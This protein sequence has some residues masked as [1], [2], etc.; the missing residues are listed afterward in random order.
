MLAVGKRGRSGGV[1]VG[2]RRFRL[3]LLRAEGI[4]KYF[5]AGGMFFRGSKPVRAVDGVDLVLERGKTLG[6][7]GESGCGKSTL[8]R[9]LLR[10]EEPTGGNLYLDGIDF[11]ALRGRE[12]RRTRR[13]IQMVFQDPYSSLNPRMSIGGT[14][15]E[16]L[17]IHGL[18]RGRAVR[19]RVAYLLDK[20]GLP[21]SAAGRYP[22]EFSGGQRQRIGIARALAVE[23][24]II[25]ADEP[26][27][28]LDVSV[29]AQIINLL[30]DL[31]ADLNL[32]CLLIAH[33]LG[34]VEHVSERVAVMYL[35]KIVEAAPAGALFARPLHPYTQGLL[36]S[37]PKPDPSAPR[38]RAAIRGDVPSPMDVPAGCSFHTRC[39]EVM[40]R[41]RTEPPHLVEIE[42]GRRVRCWLH[43]PTPS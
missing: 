10:L 21:P 35:G 7:V 40:P 29:R 30:G 2:G 37:I 8:A 15:S 41:C 32:A 25:V 20:V 11:L 22:H 27:S 16:G 14:I 26:V 5:R 43:A 24:D 36:A 28:A 6:L 23:P 4:K 31:Q 17:R 9:V 13:R 1:I 12:L 19:E 38:V 42:P 34:V 39:P 3:E 33:D 18:A